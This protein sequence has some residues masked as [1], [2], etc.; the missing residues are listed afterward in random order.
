MRHDKPLRP[1]ED[2]CWQGICGGKTAITRV[3]RFDVS[4]FQARY[5]VTVEGLRYHD[6]ESLVMQMADR[7]FTAAPTIPEDAV[8]F[9]ATTKGEI[10]ILEKMLLD[11]KTGL[12]APDP[13]LFLKKIAMRAGVTVQGL[14]ISAACASSVSAIARAASMIRNGRIDCALVVACDSVMEFV[15]AGFSFLMALD[16]AP[17]RPFDRSRSGLSIGEAAAYMLIMSGER[18]RR[19]GWDIATEVASWGLSDD[20]NHMTGP[21][22]TSEGMLSAI[23]KRLYRRAAQ[24]TI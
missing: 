1:W 14:T 6:G 15:F 19:D 22:R 9:L 12:D 17:A 24:R 21:S 18:V 5:A 16:V 4:A 2:A 7:L 20:A 23:K 10:D 13:A 3:D 8:P 11:G